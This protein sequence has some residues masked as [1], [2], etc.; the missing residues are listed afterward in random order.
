MGFIDFVIGF[1][2][3]VATSIEAE[4]GGILGQVL[5][6]VGSLDAEDDD[7]LAGETSEREDLYGGGGVLFNPLP[8][9]TIANKKYACDVVYAKRGDNLVPIAYRDLRLSR[10]FPSGLKKGSTAVVGYGGGF[11]SLDLTSANSGTKKA[12]IHVVYCPYDFDGSG[13]AQKAHSVILDPTT[14]NESVSIT[15]GSGIQISMT[16]AQGI[17]FN[18]AA[19]SWAQ[20]KSGLAVIQFPKIMVKGVVYLGASAE[21]GVPLLPGAG[22]PPGPSIYISPA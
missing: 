2:K 14:G 3:I 9:E 20:F 18:I 8:P 1:G 21:T 16:E 17:L 10:A 4:T 13:A 15:H 6:I 19:D 5:G 22:S 12:N 11:Y 7:D